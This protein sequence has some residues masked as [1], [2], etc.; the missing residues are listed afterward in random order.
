MSPKQAFTSAETRRLTEFLLADIVAIAADAIICID[1]EQNITLFNDGAEQIFGWAA[2][3]MMGKPLNVLLPERFRAG[4][5][6]HVERF[7]LSKEKARRM[8]ERREIA[9]LRK[10]GEEFPAEAAIAKVHMGDS[11]VYSVVLRDITEQVQLQKRLQRAVHAR[12]ETVGVVAH[13]LRNPVSAVKMLASALMTGE[14]WETLSAERRERVRLIREAALQMDRLIQDLLDITRV[15]S[16]RLAVNPQTFTIVALLDTALQTLRPLVEE[17]GLSL[18]VDVPS[19]LP[20]VSADPERVRQ[21]VSNLIGNAL[22][23]TP[24]GGRISVTAAQ[25]ADM[26]RVTVRDTGSGISREQLPHLFERYWEGT[27]TAIRSKGA[28]LGLPISRG[29]VNAHGGRLW[30][31]SEP[32]QGASFHFTLPIAES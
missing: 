18:V 16:G 22:K 13:D 15:E 12:D 6:A 32:G 21:V 3:E 14:E 25:D 28:G 5:R 27:P 29:I 9:G 11:V 8:G 23:F 7:G 20:D 24:S 1:A 4:H 17:A 26:V 2:D 31:E 30:V 10:N 19:T